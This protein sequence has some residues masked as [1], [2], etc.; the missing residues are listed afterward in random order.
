MKSIKKF[1]EYELNLDEGEIAEEYV[2]VILSKYIDSGD[3][4][5]LESVYNNVIRGDELEEDQAD[6][7][8][9]EITEYLYNLWEDSK[10]IQNI[11]DKY[12]L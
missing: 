12:N 9:Q 7:I 5:T 4:E 10:N 6:I 2:K 1:E 3:E 8:K 11:I